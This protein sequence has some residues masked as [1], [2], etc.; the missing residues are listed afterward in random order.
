MNRRSRADWLQLG[1]VLAACVVLG[2]VLRLWQWGAVPPAPYWEEVALGYDAWSILQ[3]GADHHGN[4]LPIVAFESFGDWKPSLYFYAVAVAEAVFGLSVTAVRVP[5]LLSGLSLIITAGLLTSVLADAVFESTDQQPQFHGISIH[6]LTLLAA[7][8]AA[9][10]QSAAPWA[11]HISRVGFEAHLAT[12]LL[13]GGILAVVWSIRYAKEKRGPHWGVIIG[14]VL[15]ALSMYAYHSL[16]VVAP[17]I[18]LGLGS[19]W[20]ATQV[21]CCSWQQ[22]LDDMQVAAC[23]IIPTLL[24]VGLL[25]APL[26]YSLTTNTVTQRFAETSRFSDLSLIEESNRM[27]DVAGDTTVARLQ[28][29]R[30]W[31]YL[32]SFLEGWMDHF[33]LDFLFLHGDENPRHGALFFGIM[34]WTALPLLIAGAIKLLR[35]RP[36]LLGALLSWYALAA[37]PAGLTKTTPHTLRVMSGLPFFAVLSG[38]GMAAI[39]SWGTEWAATWNVP[40]NIRSVVPMLLVSACAALLTLEAVWFMRYYHAA[41]ASR[42]SAE[43]QYGYAEMMT[44]VNTLTDD[45]DTPIIISRHE[46]RPAM[47]YWF[48][49]QTD[50]RAVQAVANEVPRDQSEFEAFQ[51]IIFPRRV[52]AAGPFAKGSILAG[53]AAEMDTLLEREEI[54][55]RETITRL[56]GSIAWKIAEV[57]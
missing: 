10:V 2:A 45:P 5:S 25:L 21:R 7:G 56:D 15:L 32:G 51:E 11:I 44:V 33:R 27:R 6:L 53:S 24:V 48:Y 37:L 49:T 55:L 46:G 14:A 47:Y 1:I 57:E 20:L 16:R 23:T 9:A 26:V 17:L 22:T 34:Q 38:L 3:T 40:R 50:P 13:T 39:V 42:S 28:Y 41:Y 31:F 8:T 35:R 43:W 29:H 54:V 4:T 36:W 19:I 18:G 30:G 12:A 52:D